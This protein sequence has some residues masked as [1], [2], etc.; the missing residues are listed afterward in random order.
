MGDRHHTGNLGQRFLYRYAAAGQIHPRQNQR[1][2]YTARRQRP[3]RDGKPPPAHHRFPHLCATM[4]LRE[5][6]TQSHYRGI[7]VHDNVYSGFLQCGD[8]GSPMFAMSRSDLAPAYT[9]GTYHRR[10]LRGCTSHHIRVDILDALLKRYVKKLMEHSSAMLAQ[11]NRDLCLYTFF[12]C[13]FFARAE[14]PPHN[15]QRIAVLSHARHLSS[16][17]V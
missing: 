3:Y 1:Q 15:R 6:R 8:C 11:L 14:N 17:Y 9:C 10:G 13:D 16:G 5:E 4:A 2:G 7:R 12:C